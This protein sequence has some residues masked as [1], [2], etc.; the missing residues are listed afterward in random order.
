MNV[1]RVTTSTTQDRRVVGAPSGPG[2]FGLTAPGVG[3]MSLRMN[4]RKGRPVVLLAFALVWSSAQC[5]ALCTVEPC[6]GAS[7]STAGEPPC[8]H[9]HRAP[10][11]QVPAPC[12]HQLL[13]ADVPQSFATTSA[14][15]A[16][17]ALMDVPT[18]AQFGFSSV[19][20]TSALTSDD[21]SPPGDQYSPGS[22]ILRI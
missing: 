12:P 8:H 22:M 14:P 2:G 11:N 4:S 10:A 20:G 6:R 5:A 7:G 16:S 18:A 19:L 17:V 1:W 13:Q 15:L 21:S 9:Q 3:M